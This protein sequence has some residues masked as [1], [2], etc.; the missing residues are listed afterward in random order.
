MNRTIEQYLRSFV[1][2]QPAEWYKFLALAEWAYNT[3]Q[4]F[5]IGVTPYEVVYNKPP[6]SIP[7]YLLGSS[8]NDAVET[9]ILT[10]EEIH[11]TLRRKLLKAHNAMKHFADK[12][13]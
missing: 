5:S 11:A 2:K 10:R 9:M 12:K 13:Q 3:S 1:H 8:R 4:H 7:S 6:P